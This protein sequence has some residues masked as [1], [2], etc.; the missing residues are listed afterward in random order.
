MSKRKTIWKSIDQVTE[1][2]NQPEAESG[3]SKQL[4]GNF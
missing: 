3:L 4:L 2:I 1:I